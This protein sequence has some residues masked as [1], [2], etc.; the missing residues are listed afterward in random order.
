MAKGAFSR[1]VK[2]DDTTKQRIIGASFGEPG[3]GKTTFWLTAPGPIIIMSFDRGLEGVVEEF[4]KVKDI[5]VD[6]YE[7]APAAGV[8]LDQQ[9]AIDLREKFTENFEHAIQNARTVVLDKE[10]D[11]W[12]LFKFAEFG[13]SEK[14]APLNWDALKG[15]LRRLYNMPKATDINFG[16][17]QGMRNEWVPQVNKNTGNKGITQSGIRIRNGMDDVE[18]LVHLNIEHQRIAVKN[19]PSRFVLNVGKSRGPGSRDVQDQTFENLTFPEF[20]QLVFPESKSE[21]WE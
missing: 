17:I 2:A 14:G 16:I 4:T 18:G 13:V 1:Y 15:R 11:V 20:A 21:D 3:T 9:E 12:G 5:Y 10:T 8:S 6:E 7:W 19:E